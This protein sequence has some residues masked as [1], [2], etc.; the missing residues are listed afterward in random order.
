MKSN[1]F[2]ENLL[3][4]LR[5]NEVLDS[6]HHLLYMVSFTLLY[7]ASGPLGD[8]TLPVDLMYGRPGPPPR[9][10]YPYTSG[11]SKALLSLTL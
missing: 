10:A 9:P 4:L 6:N 1:F 3:H 2:V 7:R 8:R 11:E 5:D